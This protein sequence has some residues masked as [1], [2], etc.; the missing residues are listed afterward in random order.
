MSSS[1]IK[2]QPTE[3]QKLVTSIGIDENKTMIKSYKYPRVKNITYPVHG[4]NQMAD[5]LHLPTTKE[6]FKYILAV[7]DLWSN[8]FDIEP[9]KSSSANDTL[10]ALKQIYNRGVL[11]MPKASLKTDNGSEF[12]A[13]F[14]KYLIDNNVTHLLGAP[15]RHKQLANIENLNRQLGRLFM[16]YLQNKTEQSGKD[17][18]EWTDILDKVRIGLNKIKK[19]PKDK[20][21]YTEPI[22]DINITDPPKYKVG[23]LVYRRLEKPDNDNQ[24]FRMGDNRYDTVVPRK[25]KF[26][27]VLPSKYNPYRYLLEDIPNVSYAEAELIPATDKTEKAFEFRAIIDKLVRGRKVLYRVWMKKQLKKDAKYYDKNILINDHNLGPEIEAFEKE[28]ANKK[29]KK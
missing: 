5:L 10:H 27:I 29:T 2:K 26:I 8:Y 1:S 16:T 6:G 17:Y 3:M 4:Y 23:D 28:L 25:I 20:N 9:I 12:K 14:D 13:V 18:N 24:K 15:Y 21:P 22:A 11:K 7:V 19:H